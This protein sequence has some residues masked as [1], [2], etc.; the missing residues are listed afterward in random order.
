[1]RPWRLPRRTSRRAAT[2]VAALCVSVL[3][4]ACSAGSP[5][6]ANDPANAKDTAAA[7]LPQVTFSGVTPNAGNWAIQVCSDSG[8]GICKK[9]GVSVKMIYSA[10]S[11][12]SVAALLAG[13]VQYTS[14]LYDAVIPVYLQNS[15]IEYVASGYDT[16]PYDLIVA[17]SIKTA[18][19]IKGKTC[20]AQNPPTIG[21]GLYLQLLVKDATN[22]ALR[23]PADYN[24]ATAPVA[25]VSS[26]VAAMKTGQLQCVADLPP[27]SG[28]LND[29]GYRTIAKSSE[30][31]GFDGLPFFGINVLK[32]WVAKNQ[33]TNIKF[34]EGYLA[35]IAWLTN[36]K[37]KSAALALLAKDAGLDKTATYASYEYVTDG[38]YPREGLI[39]P[40]AIA[41]D[42]GL[43]QQFGRE[44]GVTAARL[45]NM[46]NMT[47]VKKA[48]SM[49]P[50]SVKC[51]AYVAG[52]VT[53]VEQP[54]CSKFFS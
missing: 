27:V 47:Y 50:E 31:A 25:V 45:K 19:D 15:N 7:T 4:A 46:V 30:L 14:A 26:A 36:P 48:Y 41:K 49:L 28:E 39:K 54:K 11:S 38:G 24:I 12:A 37:N 21:D 5:S 8:I 34:L 1:V 6:K 22:G 33:S 52:S 3:A 53:K 43:A 17:P 23:Y 29:L 35:S 18:M 16:L 2:V 13:S 9:Y 42:L 51:E 40:N 10:D 44:P 32:S 20:G